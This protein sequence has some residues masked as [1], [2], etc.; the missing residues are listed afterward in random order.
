MAMPLIENRPGTAVM[1]KLLAVF[2]FMVMSAMIKIAVREVPAGEAVFFRSF[3]CIPV[4]LAWLWQTGELRHGLSTN[5]PMGHVWR[6]LFGTAAMTLT[7]MGLGLLPLPEVTAIGYATPMFTVIFAIFLL[8]EK[9]RAIR[10][11]A[12]GLGLVGVLIVIWPNLT[13]GANDM[14]QAATMGVLAI[15]GAS[16]VRGLVQIHI[17]RLVQTEHT[18]AIV[19]YFSL[20]ATALSLLTLPFGW[21]MPSTSNLAL[22]VGAGIIGGVAQ[23]LMTS[24]FR[25]GAA[26]ML[27]PFDYASLIFATLI[28]FVIF[29]EI[30]TWS[31]VAGAMLVVTGGVLI[32]W[33]ER[34]LGLERGRA[35]AV[36]DPKG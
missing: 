9:V 14:S 17:R 8:N 4:I 19:F 15:L 7:F 30:P 29:S 35:R 18:A 23:I 33:R 5:N 21:V 22:L 31:T 32:I 3:F 25:F 12:V 26:S 11:T 24:A 28:G 1:L 13:L 16:L 10:L 36:T 2:L 20:T 6:G 34:Q 27:A